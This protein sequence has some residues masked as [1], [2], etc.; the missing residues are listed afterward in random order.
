M[1][2]N[3]QVFDS[4]VMQATVIGEQENVSPGIAMKNRVEYSPDLYSD[5][6]FLQYLPFQTMF[7]SL[8][9]FEFAAR[10][11]SEPGIT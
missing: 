1:F 6:Q 2:G 10:E 4:M 9:V 11:F 3:A 7:G 8:T 5:P